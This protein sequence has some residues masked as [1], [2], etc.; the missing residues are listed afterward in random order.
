MPD[1]RAPFF[2][3]DRT[4]ECC[5]MDASWED[6]IRRGDVQIVRDL[7]GRGTDV[8]ARDR[9][10]QTA[11]MLAAHAGHREVVETLIAH[12]ANLNITAKFGLSALMLALIAG[13]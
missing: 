3:Q 13:H 7:L 2:Q 6:A 9:Y 1:L 4:K 12:R 11:I 8:D 10:G 5:V